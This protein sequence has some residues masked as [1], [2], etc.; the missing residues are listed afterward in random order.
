[1][2]K[3][4]PADCSGAAAAGRADGGAGFIRNPKYKYYDQM[5]HAHI[6]QILINYILIQSR[7]H[8]PAE[9]SAGSKPVKDY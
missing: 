8:N 6:P 7:F 3:T 5:T 1:M 2:Y 9:E 4:A